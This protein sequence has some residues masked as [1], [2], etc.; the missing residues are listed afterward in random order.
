L[1]V[2]EIGYLFN[3]GVTSSQL[4]EVSV[5]GGKSW[6]TWDSSVTAIIYGGDADRAQKLFEEWICATNEADPKQTEIKKLIRTELAAQLLIESGAQ[7]LDWKEI[8]E[9]L[10]ESARLV[11]SSGS[12]STVEDLGEGYW[13]DANQAVPPQSVKLDLDSLKRR[14]PEDIASGLNWSPDKKFLFLLSSLKALPEIQPDVEFEESES[15]KE[16]VDSPQPLEQFVASLPEMRE[17][18][19][20]GLVEAR[21]A[22]VAAWLWRKFATSMPN[23]SPEIL[24][25]PCCAI[26]PAD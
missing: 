21:N 8:S 17:K 16:Q 25:S 19:A 1:D 24:L 13:L 23:V 12:A 11:E 6:Q 14:L 20:A 18:D 9:K 15:G 7:P 2:N 26:I 5:R 10:I 22:V 3:A 4:R